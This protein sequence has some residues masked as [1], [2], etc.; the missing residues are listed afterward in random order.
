[1][2]CALIGLTLCFA[3]RPLDPPLDAGD[4][5]FYRVNVVP[6][7]TERVLP[8]YT[9]HVKDGQILEMGPSD[10]LKPPE[11]S[12]LIDGKTDTYLIPG[13]CDMHFHLYFKGDL[14]SLLDNG[15]TTIRN[16]R[17]R[18]SDLDFRKQIREGDIPG[19][20]IF[21]A[22]PI[23]GGP[24]TGF[25]N[26]KTPE[27]A[28]QTVDEQHAKGYDF[29]KVYDDIPKAPYLATIKEAHRLGM[30]VAGHI[31]DE[32]RVLGT[33]DAH[34]DSLEHAEQFVY[35]Y[36][37]KSMDV[38]GIPPLTKKVKKSGCYVCPTM[39]LIHN[40]IE[41]VDDRQKLMSRPEIRFANPETLEFWKTIHKDSAGYNRMIAWFQ[42]KLIKSFADA[43]VPLLSGTDT[44]IIG[45][46][47]GFSLHREFQWMAEAG[48]TP[49][50]V[51]MSSTSTPGKYL[52]RKTGR[53]AP[54]YQADLVLVRA[55]P[56][57]SVDALQQREGVMIRGKW[58]PQSEL[59]GLM[60]D[61]LKSYK[62]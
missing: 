20:T 56:L 2:I 51:L 29:I 1:M 33:L 10:L 55:N 11:N 19:P 32:L 60:E 23:L 38:D 45:F 7:D 52:E 48:L 3:T 24:N 30:K 12:R 17:G 43:G 13:L 49:Y 18:Q 58:H 57:E 25:L 37:D 35:D 54:G 46:V 22:G 5:W 28:I 31:P 36:F 50:Q 9:V 42:S 4:T 41:L 62:K 14:L 6:M 40:F 16:M 39:G 27:Q 26:I 15:V 59:N 61:L 53:I 21:T 47:P 44:H 8:V 34:Q